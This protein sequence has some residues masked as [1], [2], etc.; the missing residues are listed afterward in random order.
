[1]ECLMGKVPN[2]AR[3]SHPFRPYWPFQGTRGMSGFSS[4]TSAASA[5]CQCANMDS[6]RCRRFG[7]LPPGLPMTTHSQGGGWTKLGAACVA[8]PCS[9]C[10]RSPQTSTICAIICMC[11]TSP[12]LEKC[13]RSAKRIGTTVEGHAPAPG[14]TPARQRL[15]RG[16]SVS[17]QT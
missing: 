10:S 16:R 1:M 3:T 6:T 4:S 12:L 15:G 13:V 11:H 8:H 5:R 2:D 9:I 17:G 14:V 7:K